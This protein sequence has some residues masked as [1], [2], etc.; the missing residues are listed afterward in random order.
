M[1]EKAV[2]LVTYQLSFIRRVD[3]IVVLEGGRPQFQ[4]SYEGFKE[5]K[6]KNR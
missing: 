3:E 5:F 1:R 2:L 6:Q 4:G